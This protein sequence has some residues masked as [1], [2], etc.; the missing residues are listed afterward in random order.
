[1]S[2]RRASPVAAFVVAT[3]HRLCPTV[4]QARSHPRRRTFLPLPCSRARPS[5]AST[6]G[7]LP[8]C[9][10]SSTQQ[11]VPGTG[12]PV[13]AATGVPRLASII[14]GSVTSLG[15]VGPR[16]F[17]VCSEL[18]LRHSFRPCGRFRG[19]ETR[20]SPLP[21]NEG[22]SLFGAVSEPTLRIPPTGA[23]G[24]VSDVRD[25]R[26]SRVSRQSVCFYTNPYRPPSTASATTT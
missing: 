11:I 14:I 7:T 3:T 18:P 4:R 21:V 26:S 10:V 19:A 25:P 24:A 8:L 6:C 2:S 5:R 13:P 16:S 9:G 15:D 1:V 12:L 23:A 22:S 17:A 20:S